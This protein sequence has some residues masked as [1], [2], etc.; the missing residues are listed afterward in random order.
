M[1]LLLGANSG[2]DLKLKPRLIYRSENS[3]ALKNCTKSTLLMLYKWNN[4]AWMTAHMFTIWFTDYFKPTLESY[5]SEKKIPFK[6]LLLIDNLPYKPRALME[7][8]NE[9][10]V[11]FMPANTTFILLSLD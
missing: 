3:R 1:T 10:N 6:I 2:K 7:M 5:C 9:I 4:K 11:V 8:Y